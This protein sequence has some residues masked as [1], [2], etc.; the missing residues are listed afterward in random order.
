MDVNYFLHQR[1][2][3]IRHL[4]DTA[5][6]PMVE[7][8]RRIEAKETPFDNPPYSE[9]GE[10]AFLD[11]WLQA[12]A[13]IE[14]LGRAGVSLLSE[15]LKQFFVNW[16]RRILRGD[17]PC[18]KACRKAF[19]DGFLAG[20][21]ACFADA[22]GI[23]WATCPADLSVV[24]QVV[25]ARNRAQHNDLVLDHIQHDDA[26]RSKFPRPFFM[27]LDEPTFDDGDPSSFMNPTLHINR[28]T[29]FEAIAH[30]EQLGTWLQEHIQS[31]EDKRWADLN[32]PAKS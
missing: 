26:T 28:E 9:D 21:R 12:D 11:E 22:F 14:V 19:E 7:T 17:K 29:L 1:A 3:F 20:Y 2:D 30:V 10:P 15:A 8:K 23:D 5:T 4:Y 18:S 32:S 16:E 6:A 27:R 13:Q 24:E 25:L 31:W